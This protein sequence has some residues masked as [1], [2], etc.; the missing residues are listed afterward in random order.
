MTKSNIINIPHTQTLPRHDPT[1]SYYFR[2]HICIE[3]GQ[4]NALSR[5]SSELG[6]REFFISAIDEECWD[7]IFGEEYS[8]DD[9]NSDED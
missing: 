2:N 5:C 8:D 7:Q 9:F 3:C 6:K 4:P 1:L